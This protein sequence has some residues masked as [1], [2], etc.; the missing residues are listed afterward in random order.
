MFAWR[1]VLLTDVHVCGCCALDVALLLIG[2]SWRVRVCACVSECVCACWCAIA[3]AIYCQT[4]LSTT[5][6]IATRLTE[7]IYSVCRV[8]LAANVTS[9]V[10]AP[11]ELTLQLQNTINK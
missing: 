9:L 6:V 10:F 7:H 8:H 3:S 11:N 4:A 1:S 5:N 2:G